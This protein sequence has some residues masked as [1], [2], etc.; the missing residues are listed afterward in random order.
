MRLVLSAASALRATRELL[1]ASTC[2]AQQHHARRA[3]G[4]RA[5]ASAGRR[6]VAAAGPG[7]AERAP[8]WPWHTRS[9]TA[10]RTAAPRRPAPR[11]PLA[12]LMQPSP[13]ARAPHLRQQVL[14][15]RHER[16]EVGHGGQVADVE[17]LCRVRHHLRGHVNVVHAHADL[18]GGAQRTH[19]R[20]RTCICAPT[21]GAPHA[22]AREGP[23]QGARMRARPAS[24]TRPA[25]CCCWPTRARAP[26]RL[27]RALH[28]LR[29]DDQRRLGAQA[30]DVRLHG[31]PHERPRVGAEP[32]LHPA[33]HA[34]HALAQAARAGRGAGQG[35][36]ARVRTRVA[37][38]A[39]VCGSGARPPRAALT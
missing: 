1:C 3:G 2:T 11:A 32:R 20:V 17:A 15:V 16:R 36:G 27:Q 30:H 31:A 35:G 12:P 24:G 34:L 37:G 29:L 28:R 14:Q 39:R 9:P 26:T 13:A 10:G 23:G 25:R 18:R 33:R 8:G 21:R 38:C 5:T 6:R 19:Q 7:G 22:C 4:E